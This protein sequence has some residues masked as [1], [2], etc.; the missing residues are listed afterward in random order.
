[1]SETTQAGVPQA[2]ETQSMLAENLAR[3]YERLRRTFALLEDQEAEDCRMEGEWSAKALLA[4]VAFWDE[5]H[6]ARLQGLLPG[7]VVTFAPKELVQRNDERAAMDEGRLLAEVIAESERARQS[8]IDFARAL[9]AELLELDIGDAQL[10]PTP[11][12]VFERLANHAR[13]H[14]L[15]LYAWCGST[16]RWTRG[17]FCALLEGQHALLLESVAGL[18]EATI[19]ATKANGPWSMRDELVHA[20]AW[21]EFS[22]HVLDGWPNVAPA[23]IA[24]WVQG[25]GEDEDDVNV[26]LMAA[27]A[28]LNMIEVADGLATWHRRVMKRL[29]ALGDEDLAVRGNYH[30]G[31]EG[32]L[33]GFFYTLCLHQAQHSEHVW[34]ARLGIQ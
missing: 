4:H 33:S 34:R 2:D 9:P 26:R 23:M 20:L 30:F 32:E 21:S 11:H 13:A 22:C 8:V 28:D 6:L 16:R 5:T 29:E 7:E 31:G 18:E 19:L 17:T 12:A 1:M 10:P 14:T 27:R 3:S 24:D 25:E 15:A